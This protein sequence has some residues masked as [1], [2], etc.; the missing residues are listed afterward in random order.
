MIVIP[1]VVLGGLVA[2]Y[3]YVNPSANPVISRQQVV[4]GAVSYGED[5]VRMV[6][7]PVRQEGTDLVFSLASVK[8]H[9]LV[10]FFYDGGKTER[11]V[12]AYID[13]QGR[14]V[15]SMS[16]SEHCGS[17]EFF[18][19]N[20]QIYCAHCPS[21]WDMMT[22][23]AYACCGRY[24]PDPIPSRVVGDDVHVAKRSVEEWAGRL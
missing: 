24:Y 7:I 10:R 2:F 13:P 8:Q 12:M 21:H 1:L 5:T 23:E 20:N 9:R 4:S 3:S 11:Y 22:M 15:T 18:L 19:L 14:L 6:D 16:I 17:T